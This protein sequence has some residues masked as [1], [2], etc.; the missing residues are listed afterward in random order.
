LP[1]D[2]QAGWQQRRGHPASQRTRHNY[3]T[4]LP[5]HWR[6][7]R[8]GRRRRNA[9]AHGCRAAYGAPADDSTPLQSIRRAR[10]QAYGTPPPADKQAVY[11]TGQASALAG[12]IDILINNASTLG[13]AARAVDR[14]ECEDLSR[15]LE[16][17]LVPRF[18]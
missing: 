7:P 16:L 17:N 3:A 18:G 11:R 8:L 4:R 9:A 15:V 14:P 5:H 6:Q 12:P 1:I 2:W 13:H 10:G